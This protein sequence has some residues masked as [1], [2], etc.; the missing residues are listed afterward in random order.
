MSAGVQGSTL[1]RAAAT[2]VCRIP[3]CPPGLAAGAGASPWPERSLRTCSPARRGGWGRRYGP[4]IKLSACGGS[5]LF[6]VPFGRPRAPQHWWHD[7][8]AG[9][10]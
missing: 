2:A 5:P 7:G 8:R 9:N 6:S 1:C 3:G 10:P 4:S